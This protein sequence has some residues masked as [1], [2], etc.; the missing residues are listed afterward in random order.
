MRAFSDVS[1]GRMVSEV[2]PQAE[3]E[4]VKPV[5][6]QPSANPP[7]GYFPQPATSAP[8]PH[9]GRVGVGRG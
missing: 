2:E 3:A 9:A 5:K 1:L 4:R 7:Q 6:L 8:F